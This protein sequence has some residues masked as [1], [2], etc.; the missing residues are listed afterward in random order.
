MT[1][2]GKDG[3][4]KL[5]RSL[6]EGEESLSS[7]DRKMNDYDSRIHDIISDDYESNQKKWNKKYGNENWR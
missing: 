5:A 6:R 3:K 7:Y 4:D 2:G 1:S